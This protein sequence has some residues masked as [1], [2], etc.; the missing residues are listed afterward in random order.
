MPD[1]NLGFG[2]TSATVQR[3]MQVSEHDHANATSVVVTAKGPTEA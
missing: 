2:P 1:H 3:V